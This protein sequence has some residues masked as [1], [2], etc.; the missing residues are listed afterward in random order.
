MPI[1][2]AP[3]EKLWYAVHTHPRLEMK[4]LAHLRRQNYEVYLPMLRRKIRHARRTEQVLRPFFPRY[5]FVA[6]NPEQQGWRAIRSTLGVSDIV[7][8]GEAPTPLPPGVIENLKSHED[9]AGTIKYEPRRIDKGAKV[10]V[11]DGPFSRLLGLC[12]AVTD[13]ERVMVLLD[14]L[15][16]KVRV[17]LSAE[18]VEAA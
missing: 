13:S 16:R 2:P 3:G 17:S 5:L 6:L 1:M 7:R 14:L 11:L 10:T 9:D 15:G 8:F 18:A 12:E 4:A